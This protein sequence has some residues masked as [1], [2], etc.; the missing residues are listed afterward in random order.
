MPHFDF[1]DIAIGHQY[2]SK[3]LAAL[4]G[5]KSHHALIRGIVTQSGNNDTVVLF[6]TKEKQAGATPYEDR[7][8]GNVLYMMGQEKHGTDQRLMRNLPNSIDT[9]HL[10]FREKHHTPFI[11]Y[12][13]CRLLSAVEKTDA[14][15]E[16]ELLLLEQA[17]DE[18]E[19]SEEA[20][21]DLLAN[22]NETEIEGKKILSQHIRYER[23][24]Q[25]RKK[26]IL[27]QGHVCRICGF[28]FDKVYGKELADAYI[29][30]HHIH[31]L[32]EGQQ[33]VDPS[34][35]LITV[36]ANCHRMLHRRKHNNISVSELQEMESVKKIR[37]IY[38][39]GF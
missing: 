36:C 2:T 14:P 4:W 25:N 15:S 9:I 10:F 31:Q 33:N 23:N 30:V 35:D 24:P 21:I 39:M 27:L 12:G 22:L 8:E 5:Y 29:E 34:K 28:D 20:V 17:G 13:T 37:A 38:E 26:A 19:E 32:S 3:E 1:K 6:V 7:I 18:G 11:Y 16:F